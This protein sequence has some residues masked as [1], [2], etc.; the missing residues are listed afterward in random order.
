MNPGARTGPL[1]TP[2]EDD[3]IRTLGAKLEA[4]EIAARLPGRSVVAIFHRWRK[5]GLR[6]NRR[7]TR[8]DDRQLMLLWGSCSLAATARRLGRTTVTTYW[9]AQKLGLGLGCPRGYEY[10]S[11]AAKRTGF[12]TATLRTVLRWAGV[13]VEKVLCRRVSGTWRRHYV[14]PDRVDQAVSEWLATET[15]EQASRRIGISTEIIVNRLRASGLPL[16]ERPGKKRRWRIPS[17]TID[18]A[19]DMVVRRGN[20]LVLREAA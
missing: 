1:W 5:L 19:V 10:L 20:K 9:R 7:W 13:H 14:N 4:K 8:A 11:A 15:P 16:P 18:R 17:E 12:D 3:V 6:K 2:A